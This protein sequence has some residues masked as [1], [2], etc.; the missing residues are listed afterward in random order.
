M[1][2]KHDKQYLIIGEIGNKKSFSSNK[3]LIHKLESSL[4]DLGLTKNDIILISSNKLV[5][6]S[7]LIQQSSNKI[8]KEN[9]ILNYKDKYNDIFDNN[10]KEDFYLF[11]KTNRYEI[12]KQQFQSFYKTKIEQSSFVPSKHLFGGGI[13]FGG[14]GN[15]EIFLSA[16]KININNNLQTQ[17]IISYIKEVYTNFKSISLNINSNNSLANLLINENLGYIYK[18]L[19]ILINYL[20]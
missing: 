15:D 11:S 18:S 7:N 10:L 13:G 4:K 6:A 5:D 16:N 20:L 9:N 1:K 2:S 8:N 17:K 14:G 3:D 12:Y 19:M